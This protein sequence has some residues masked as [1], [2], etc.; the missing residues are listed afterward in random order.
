[1]PITFPPCH[2]AVTP[3]LVLLVGWPLKTAAA[4]STY[5]KL[6]ALPPTIHWERGKFTW[7][8]LFTWFLESTFNAKSWGKKTHKKTELRERKYYYRNSI[9]DRLTRH[10]CVYIRTLSR[11]R[12]QRRYSTLQDFVETL[13]STCRSSF[14]T[15][16][17]VM[18][19][20]WRFS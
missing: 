15:S 5:S 19:L 9:L 11:L 18:V 14:K 20:N 8:S 4:C 17:S 10:T 16:H 13:G 3:L 2:E 6:V 12:T 1:M 7:T